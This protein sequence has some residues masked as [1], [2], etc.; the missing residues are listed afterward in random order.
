MHVEELQL[1]GCAFSHH[2]LKPN[3]VFICFMDYMK[4]GRNLNYSSNNF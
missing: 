2:T 1:K 3:L 4:C